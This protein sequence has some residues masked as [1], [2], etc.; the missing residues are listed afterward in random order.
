VGIARTLAGVPKHDHEL[1]RDILRKFWR[2]RARTT[3]LSEGVVRE[4]LHAPTWNKFLVFG[5]KDADGNDM[6]VNR[7]ERYFLKARPGDHLVCPF[8]CDGYQFWKLKF[9]EPR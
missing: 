8:E 5:A 1:G 2:A 3:S 9:R 7:E 4:M 6:M